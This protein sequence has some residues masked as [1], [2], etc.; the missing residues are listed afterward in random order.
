[1][2]GGKQQTVTVDDEAHYWKV[3]RPLRRREGQED[4]ASTATLKSGATGKEVGNS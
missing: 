2:S 1:M 4:S 3:I